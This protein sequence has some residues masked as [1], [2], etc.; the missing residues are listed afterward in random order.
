MKTIFALLLLFLP[1]IV[2]AQVGIPIKFT[3]KIDGLVIGGQDHT[4]VELGDLEG[5]TLKVDL[6][7]NTGRELKAV[8]YTVACKMSDGTIDYL[9]HVNRCALLDCKIP[10]STELGIVN[11]P[12]GQ[13]IRSIEILLDYARFY[14]GKSLGNAHNEGAHSIRF[15]EQAEKMYRAYLTKLAKEGGLPALLKEVDRP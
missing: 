5:A 14:D 8:S 11:P 12:K 1:S 4:D 10:P 3:S 6:T 2:Q 7:N 15:G 13:D 9:T